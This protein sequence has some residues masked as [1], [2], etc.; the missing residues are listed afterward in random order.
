MATFKQGESL[1]FFK[2][3]KKETFKKF[4]EFEDFIQKYRKQQKPILHT[5][6]ETKKAEKTIKNIFN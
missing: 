5:K 3:F 4:N 2:P 1:G 6:F